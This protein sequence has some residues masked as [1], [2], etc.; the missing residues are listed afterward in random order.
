MNFLYKVNQNVRC[1]QRQAQ[2]FAAVFISLSVFVRLHFTYVKLRFGCD[3]LC[4]TVEA[5][6]TATATAT[7]SGAAGERGPGGGHHG[8]GGHFGQI[9]RHGPT[10]A[11][12]H[13]EWGSTLSIF[14]PPIFVFYFFFFIIFAQILTLISLTLRI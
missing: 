6:G 5:G 1:N 10:H 7:A 4:G 14:V 12:K 13:R 2:S 3:N 8:G 9:A 11:G